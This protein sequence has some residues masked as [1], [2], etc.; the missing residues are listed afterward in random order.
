MR[1]HKTPFALAAIALCGAL[2][3]V[4]QT[5]SATIQAESMSRSNYDTEGSLIKVRSTSVTGTATT[6]FS[7]P[8]GT[9]NIQVHVMLENDGRPT[10]ELWK[11]TST[12][13]HTYT[14]PS[15][16]GLTPASYT[17]SNVQLNSGDQ[18]R[19]VGRPNGDAYARVDKIVLT[20]VAGAPSTGTETGS[21]TGYQGTPFSGTPIAL[22]KAFPASDFDRGGQNVAYFD[23]SSGNAGNAYRT[24]DSVDIRSR[25]DSQSNGYEVYNFETGEWMAYTVNVPKTGAY[26]LAIRAASNQATPAKFHIEVDGVNVTGSVAVPNTGSWSTYQWVGKQG[27]NLTAG[28]RVI[29]VVS[30][31]QYFGIN[32]LSVL[33]SAPAAQP[34]AG[35]SFKAPAANA[36]LSGVINQSS[37]CE[38]AGT[39]IKQ[40]RFSLG[41]TA[42][43]TEGSAPWQCNIDTRKFADGAHLLKAAVTYSDGRTGNVEVPV[44]IKNSTT[45]P[46]SPST[47]PIIGDGV[48]GSQ[49]LYFKAP[50]SNQALS[51]NISQSSACEVGGTNI[52]Q[53]RFSLGST[54]LNTEGGAPWQCNIDTTKFGN[55]T[56]TLTAVATFTN[57][58]TGAVSVPVSINNGSAPAPNPS[59][60]TPTPTGADFFCSFEN[61]PTD[62]GFREQAKVSGRA[63]LVDNP[64]R[65]GGKA[66]RLHTEPGD[67]N[68]SGSGTNGHR[69]D[70]TL[71]Q[72]LTDCYAGKEQWWAHSLLLPN[73]FIA[74][75]GGAVIANFH[76]TGSFGQ[77]NFQIAARPDG[78]T[79][80]GAGGANVVTSSDQPGVYIKKIGPIVKNQWYDFVYHVKWS[81]G[82]DGFM[83]AWVNGV[84]VVAHR[85]PT[86]YT[87]QGCYLKLANYHMPVGQGQ[88]VIHDRVVRG[89]SAAAV[90]LTPLQG[91]Q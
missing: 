90:S 62:C 76:Q 91:M 12:R 82:S 54:A 73:D 58:R 47:P 21:S 17:I 57:G 44:L 31:Q 38:V 89:K 88:S 34:A 75:S 72:V 78:L 35:T 48:A 45:S 36:Q 13:L 19:L 29:K 52:K 23:R 51:G 16:S 26:D 56:H 85:G 15:S 63:T 32:A 42:L 3:I 65:H 87:G 46:S 8:S 4:A 68:V 1:F 66:V 49:A 71:G 14:Y 70:L 61:S 74:P 67:T 28:K 50:A 64:R 53:V 79:F 30:E 83:N 7:G 9:Y 6:T 10:L 80:Y 25:A 37:A 77:A 60:P 2:P 86:L 24:S 69:N 55:G 39:N 40:V 43:N 27:I 22:P 33:E 84:Q 81:S 11:G 59:G 5:T 20:Q 18:L 41:S